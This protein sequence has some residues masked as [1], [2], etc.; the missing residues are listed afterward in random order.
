[1]GVLV[2]KAKRFGK[3][4]AEV[5]FT[6]P[7]EKSQWHVLEVTLRDG[8]LSERGVYAVPWTAVGVVLR[9]FGPQEV[10][11]K[12]YA[13]TI[14]DLGASISLKKR[15][16]L[17]NSLSRSIAS[18][19]SFLKNALRVV[20]GSPDIGLSPLGVPPV[21]S[22]E[23]IMGRL[24]RRKMG[25]GEVK[26]GPG[27]NADRIDNIH[28]VELAIVRGTLGVTSSSPSVLPGTLD[29]EIVQRI[30]KSIRE[31]LHRG[32]RPPISFRQEDEEYPV[33]GK[34]VLP[35]VRG[36]YVVSLGWGRYKQCKE[37]KDFSRIDWEKLSQ[38]YEL[39][40]IEVL[41]SGIG[42]YGEG[43]V[44]SP[45]LSMFEIG[46]KYDDSIVERIRKY[47]LASS[48]EEWACAAVELVEAGL[49]IRY[50]VYH[51]GH[52]VEDGESWPTKPGVVA[53][54]ISVNI[55][56][57]PLPLEPSVVCVPLASVHTPRAPHICNYHPIP[58]T[59]SSLITP[60]PVYLPSREAVSGLKGKDRAETKKSLGV[61]CSL[62]MAESKQ[63]YKKLYS[64]LLD[65]SPYL[66][67]SKDKEPRV[68]LGKTPFSWVDLGPVSEV[69]N[70]E[71]ALNP[72]GSTDNTVVVGYPVIF[73]PWI[74][75]EEGGGLAHNIGKGHKVGRL[76]IPTGVAV[77]QRVNLNSCQEASL[78]EACSVFLPPG[79]AYKPSRS[80]HVLFRPGASPL[81]EVPI[82]SL[83][84][85]VDYY[86][87]EGQAG[88][89]DIV[90]CILE[91]Q[92]YKIEREDVYDFLL[93]PRPLGEKPLCLKE[94]ARRAL[95]AAIAEVKD[96][97]NESDKRI[98]R[99]LH[100]RSVF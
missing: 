53:C 57:R 35:L 97:W 37:C 42:H 45:L 51:L 75:L 81:F 70:S 27:W 46:E 76:D 92:E 15:N 10:A 44:P 100:Y 16:S 63:D 61:I 20:S 13:E 12:V 71:R 8:E 86:K 31:S 58:C 43:E 33:Y 2:V 3:S 74:D 72:S 90:E 85:Q 82:S 78:D 56:A 49:P 6:I 21:L 38:E 80:G 60:Y 34:A 87:Q 95:T 65:L 40:L 68:F 22:N 25:P 64:D 23:D 26:L 83:K 18:A 7:H 29:C 14:A 54:L 91:E 96:E 9:R 48:V 4:T 98:R 1:M 30:G 39:K 69:M 94:D 11:A 28:P 93:A 59:G 62:A 77:L 55:L 66:V 32:N 47:T 67:V 17:E 84:L 24:P 89:L 52:H 36:M 19:D 5:K 79:T 99:A 50:S 41:K 73:F 88:L